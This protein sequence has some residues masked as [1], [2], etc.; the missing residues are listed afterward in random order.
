MFSDRTVSF[1]HVSL[2]GG[3]WPTG[4]PV[5]ALY[6]G[7]SLLGDPMIFQADNHV[8]WL[9]EALLMAFGCG[10]MIL[11]PVLHVLKIRG[12]MG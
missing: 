12:V 8:T 7:R 2:H 9:W 5:A 6:E 10:L 4:K 3:R 11:A 1:H